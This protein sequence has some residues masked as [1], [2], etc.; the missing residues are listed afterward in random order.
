LNLSGETGKE[1]TSKIF[2]MI[3]EEEILTRNRNGM[4]Y[5][6]GEILKVF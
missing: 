2:E 1:I 4:W 5:S 6:D 3:F